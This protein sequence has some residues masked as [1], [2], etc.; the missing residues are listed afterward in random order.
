MK[1]SQSLTT[2]IEEC[3]T[4]MLE[5]GYSEKSILTYCQIWNSKLI[6]FLLSIG[7]KD[8]TVPI[9]NAFLDTLP[10]EKVFGTSRLRRSI[11]IL[12][13]VLTTG[14]IE[15][16]VPKKIVPDFS[17]E[18]GSVFNRLIEKERSL[19]VSE[20][21]IYIYTR[22]LDR[23][24]TFLRLNSI[25]KIDDLNDQNLLDFVNSNQINQSQRFQV[26]KV[27]CRFLVEESNKPAYFGTLVKGYK[28]PIKEKLPSVYSDEERMAI[29]KAINRKELGGKRL[30]AAFLLGSLLGL[31]ISDIIN[32]RFSNI[33]WE[34]N[35]I[36]L[37]QYKTSK[38]VELPLLEEVGLALIDYIKNERNNEISDDHV[39]LTLKPP[40]QGVSRDTI[41]CGLQRAI[42]DSGVEV[43]RRHHGMH[44]MRH[45]LA[46][47]L[48]KNDET[49]PM[50]AEVLGHS[51]TNSTK[52]YLRVD[53]EGLKRCLL[54]I[55]PVP[56]SFYEQKGGIFYE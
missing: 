19:R 38:R 25:T 8:Y 12:N 6:P 31:R 5:V 39:F 21:T 52:P 40:Y 43:G 29:G 9:G 20:R 15:R 27:L 56:K 10:K 11:T 18:I 37:S 1:E 48:L 53:I 47:K 4:L 33:D 42:C 45:S 17:G 41:S 28:F 54:P 14:K 55:P 30:Y 24:M 49:L 22:M 7:V 50:I 35:V 34:R 32:L 3:K 36:T 16:H 51:S 26:V 46:T 2:L 44:A 13:T 23:L